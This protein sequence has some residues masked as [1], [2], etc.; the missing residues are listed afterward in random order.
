MPNM[1]Y[2]VSNKTRSGYIEK[3]LPSR[4]RY[5]ILCMM[6]I[7]LTAI[8]ALML[9][10]AQAL[11]RVAARRDGITLATLPKVLFSPYFIAGAALYVV[12][13]LVY[14]YLQSKYDF[15][16]VQ[17]ILVSLSLI[18]S[19]TIAY[20]FFSEKF[21]TVNMLG[22]LLLLTGVYLILRK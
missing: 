6:I 5:G 9:S 20:I 1:Y 11:W 4:S 14:L 15:S 13:T 22:V 12:A 21:T 19:F 7:I 16:H 3:K 2:I 18:A 10:A 17:A 8:V